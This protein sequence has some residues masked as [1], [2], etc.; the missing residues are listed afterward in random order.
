MKISLSFLKK[1]PELPR[2]FQQF[3]MEVPLS[4]FSKFPRKFSDFPKKFPEVSHI[5]GSVFR[6]LGEVII[7]CVAAEMDNHSTIICL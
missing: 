5:S 3:S 4:K 6:S 1:L 2:K 7:A